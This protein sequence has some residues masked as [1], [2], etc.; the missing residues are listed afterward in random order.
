MLQK[1]N[2][3]ER[4]IEKEP[5]PDRYIDVLGR[6]VA[7]L[8]DIDHDDETLE[9]AF[10]VWL[11]G[12]RGHLEEKASHPIGEKEF[13]KWGKFGLL[14]AFDLLFW[15]QVTGA[16]FTDALIA[17]SIWG[18]DPETD[19]YVDLTERFRKVT[20]PLVS[21]VFDWG[22]VQRFWR[23]MELEKAL[24]LMIERDKQRKAKG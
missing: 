19:D 20:R 24:D 9:L 23:Q 4:L 1:M 5:G 22:Y 8:V 15:A 10:K 14:P 7:I 12:A 6:R 17:R 21:E 3:M 11:A 16:R 18:S 13:S 2:N